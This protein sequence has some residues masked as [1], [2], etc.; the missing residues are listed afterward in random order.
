MGRVNIPIIILNI[1]VSGVAISFILYA[2]FTS[3]CWAVIFLFPFGLVLLIC[4][5]T[6]IIT[7]LIGKSKFAFYVKDESKE[8]SD[9]TED[10][11]F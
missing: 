5:I 2:Y 7:T 9:A 3:E 4:P 8:L 6:C 11:E 1:I 10:E